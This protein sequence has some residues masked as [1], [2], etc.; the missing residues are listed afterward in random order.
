MAAPAKAAATSALSRGDAPEVHAPPSVA[1]RGHGEAEGARR[2]SHVGEA[3][4]GSADDGEAPREVLVAGGDE[5]PHGERGAHPARCAPPSVDGA[6]P[7]GE[8]APAHGAGDAA[9]LLLHGRPLRSHASTSGRSTKRQSVSSAA[10][11]AAGA[12]APA[13]SSGRVHGSRNW[14][15][16]AAAAS[17][18]AGWAPLLVSSTRARARQSAAAR[19]RRARAAAHRR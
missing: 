4:G 18:R 8:A 1:S 9:Q 17:T 14:P 13:T 3:R 2:R 12:C 19:R 6:S 11:A 16:A 10:R 7:L 5:L 15:R